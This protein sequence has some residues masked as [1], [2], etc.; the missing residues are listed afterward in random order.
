M[1]IRDRPYSETTKAYL[2][3]AIEAD[4]MLQTLLDGLER[5]GELDNTLIV[6]CACL[7]YTS[8][9]V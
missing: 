3:A 7:L 8:R 9:C 5:A 1:C 6:A 4:R 2:A